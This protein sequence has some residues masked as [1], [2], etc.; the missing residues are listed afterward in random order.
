MVTPTSK[1]P[2]KVD[3]KFRFVL[4]A[5]RRAEQLMQGARAR[6]ESPEGKKHTRIA[7]EEV[8]T[9][10][11]AWDYGLEPEEE[12]AAAEEETAAEAEAPAE[13]DDEVH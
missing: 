2:E 8:R 13:A 5:A 4:V 7:Q 6:L 9:D 12:A 3:S 11:V 1:M 10:M